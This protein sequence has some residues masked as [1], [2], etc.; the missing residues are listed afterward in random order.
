[1]TSF[2]AWN[3]RGFNMSRKHGAVRN[4]VH[5][6]KPLFGCLL[7]TRLREENCNKCMKAALPGWTAITNYDH[8]HLGRIWLCWSDKVVVTRLHSSAQVITCAV[9]IPET[10]EQFLCSAVYASNLEG[11]RRQLWEELHGVQAAYSHLAMPWIVLGDFNATLAS[12][13]HSR[14]NDY[15]ADQMGMRQFQE[16]IHDCALSDMPYVG[17]LFTWWKITP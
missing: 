9:Q 1:M 15:L 4:W 17:A 16:A 6:E 13:E 3:M 5:A 7:E 14:V 8:H 10:K 2:F 11:E 12:G